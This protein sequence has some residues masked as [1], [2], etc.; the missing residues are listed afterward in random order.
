MKKN[1][2][3]TGMMVECR[4]GNVYTVML[5]VEVSSSDVLV[6]PDGWMGLDSYDNNMKVGGARGWDIMK[7]YK[8]TTE[9]QIGHKEDCSLIWE[10]GEEFT[11]EDLQVGMSVITR[12]GKGYDVCSKV[13]AKKTTHILF[14]NDGTWRPLSYYEDNLIW[15][16]GFHADADIMKVYSDRHLVYEREE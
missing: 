1:D 16:N 10:R 15:C 13:D 7:V 2:L 4:N 6:C 11:K 9:A 3:K 8:P 12:E 14:C 5:G